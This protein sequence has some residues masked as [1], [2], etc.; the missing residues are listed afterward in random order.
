MQKFFKLFNPKIII[1]R[2][3]F[4]ALATSLL[5][6]G[7]YLCLIPALVISIM[8]AALIYFLTIINEELRDSYSALL[9]LFTFINSKNNYAWKR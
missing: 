9:Q 3:Y 1:M 5:K 2:K 4:S 6:F 7:V 8:G